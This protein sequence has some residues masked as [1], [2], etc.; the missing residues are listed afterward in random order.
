M[1]TNIPV[2]ELAVGLVILILLS[3]FFSGAETGL[4]ALNRYRLRHLVLQGH[5][6]AKL[7][8][9]LLLRPDRLLG[10][11]LIGNTFSVIVASSL[12]TIIAVHFW[13][14]AGVAIAT[15]ALTL[16]ILIF[17]EIS[18]KTLAAVYPKKISFF[19][20]WP[21]WILLW[22]LYPIV[23][24][25][26][27][28]ANTFLRIFGVRVSARKAIDF[29]NA[30][31]LGTV[32]REAGHTISAEDQQMLLSI[33]ELRRITVEDIMVPRSEIFALDLDDEWDDILDF[34][35]STQQEQILVCQGNMNNIVGVL[36]LRTVL[37]LLL[38]E[39]FDKDKLTAQLLPVYFVAESTSLASQLINFR[40]KKRYLAVVVNE[41]GD[42]QG[43]VNLYDIFAE[44]VGEF[45]V[46]VDTVT[47]DLHLQT[48]GSYI[49]DG[50]MT[51]RELNKALNLKFSLT[52]PKTLSG[53]IVEELQDI[54]T[55][56]T[57]IKIANC[58][59]EIL[60]VQDNMVKAAKLSIE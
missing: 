40:R 9:R 22:L 16:I 6:T 39:E 28:F 19:V 43:V 13:G 2:A 36:H 49:V 32:V 8:Q 1:L 56:H 55:S 27:T 58:P 7:I 53:L 54:P 5:R 45:V 3:A 17:A 30:E 50:S 18:P 4:M 11:I 47:V 38:D 26:N 52:G 15:L 42:I 44:I 46:D 60:S 23:W 33:L 57:C 51:L 20:A 37:N 59:I 25:G 29:L 14:D 12:A 35:R 31:E 34:L 24:L 48:D 10:I 21:L 41:Y